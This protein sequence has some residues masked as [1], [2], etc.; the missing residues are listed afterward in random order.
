MK[1]DLPPSNAS[2][3]EQ[4]PAGIIFSILKFLS[5]SGSAL[6]CFSTLF[7]MMTPFAVSVCNPFSDQIPAI[8]AA[9]GSSFDNLRHVMGFRLGERSVAGHFQHSR[10]EAAICLQL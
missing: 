1:Q 6:I 8:R 9:C 4:S 3:D 10:I 7:E 5:L 2:S